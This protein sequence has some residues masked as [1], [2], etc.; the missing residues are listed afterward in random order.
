MRC[1]V[2]PTETVIALKARLESALGVAIE[3][4]QLL[5]W[6]ETL[7]NNTT[8]EDHGIPSGSGLH[9]VCSSREPRLMMSLSGASDGGLRLWSLENG[10]LMMDLVT[11]P[12]PVVWALSVDWPNMRAISGS[13]NGVV[14]MWDLSNQTCVATIESHTEEV[15]TIESNWSIMRALTGSGDGTVKVWDLEN[16]KVIQT[17]LCGCTVFALAPDWK[18]PKVYVGL[19]NGVVTLLDLNTGVELASYIG[20]VTAAA[21]GGTSMSAI[22]IDA[23]SQRAVSGLEDGH[24]L[25]W[26]LQ[27]SS[28]ES[29]GGEKAKPKV[30]MLL[31]HYCAIRA[32]QAHWAETNSRALCGSDDGSLSMWSLD[33]HYCV[34]RCARHIGF[35]WAIHV[36]WS[37]D[38]AITGAF[39]GCTKLWDLRTGECLR[40]LQ[41][42]SRP[43]RSIT[44]G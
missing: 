34:I 29:T 2:P 27:G 22:A 42:H 16:K 38:R 3:S 12:M 23:V 13:A 28:N 18:Y 43:V 39:D 8:L 20:G 36:D 10:E 40:T 1:T 35:V 24:L 19:K 15:I 25:Y 14:H 44:A 5:W 31:A 26:H 7:P 11:D 9:L 4:Q 32:I 17:L 37:K 30:K 33:N 21:S 41:C 6:A